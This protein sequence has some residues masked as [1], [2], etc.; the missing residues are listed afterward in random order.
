MARVRSKHNNLLNYFIH[1]RR[2]LRPAYV[3]SCEKFFKN[4]KCPQA[5]ASCRP[6]GW[7]ARIGSSAQARKLSSLTGPEL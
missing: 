2:D 3:A 7:P 1:D 4:L 6:D 5:A